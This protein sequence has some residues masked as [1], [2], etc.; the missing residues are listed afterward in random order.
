MYTPPPSPTIA[1]KKSFDPL[2]L[3]APGRSLEDVKAER[4][5]RSVALNCASQITESFARVFE[6]TDACKGYS[7]EKITG[8]LRAIKHSEFH[9]NLELLGV[10]SKEEEKIPF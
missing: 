4:I 8:L 7:D 3:Q 5:A 6:S 9:D 2:D 10:K 1:P